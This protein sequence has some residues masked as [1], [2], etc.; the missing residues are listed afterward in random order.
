MAMPFKEVIISEIIYTFLP[1][2]FSVTRLLTVSEHVINFMII[3]LF[4][5]LRLKLHLCLSLL[6]CVAVTIN[7]FGPRIK[8]S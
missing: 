4:L 8:I 2:C 3:V 7:W 1:D 6:V 5:Y